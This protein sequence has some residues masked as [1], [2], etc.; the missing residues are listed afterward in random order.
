MA[1]TFRSNCCGLC[2]QG[3][4]A[5]EDASTAHPKPGDLDWGQFGEEGGTRGE[6]EKAE[7][8]E[9]TRKNTMEKKKN[10]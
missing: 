7:A 10:A 8:P 5:L 9:P 3:T 4:F 1:L 6:V 2:T